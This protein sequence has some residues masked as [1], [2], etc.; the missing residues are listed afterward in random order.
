LSREMRKY[1]YGLNQWPP[2]LTTGVFAVQWLMILVPGIVVMGEVLG[3]A[4]G[5]TAPQRVEFVQ[6]LFLV[7]GATQIAQV[8]WGHRLPGLVGPAGVLMVGV[9]G[10]LSSGLDVVYWS[11]TWAALLVTL[12]G[13]SGQAARLS[14][15]FT[16]PVLAA[17]LLLLAL[18]LVPVA[19]PSVFHAQTSGGPAGSLAFVMVLVLAMYAAERHFKGLFSSAVVL[20]GMVLGSLVFHLTGLGPSQEI[21]AQTGAWFSLPLKSIGP[22]RFDFGVLISFLLCYLAVISNEVAANEAVGRMIGVRGMAKRMNWAVLLMGLGG[23]AGGLLGV[24]GPVTYSAGPAML[25][26]TKSA[27]RFTLLPA[28]FL[29]I[30][31]GLIPGG[32]SLFQ[33]MP[34]PVV[35]GVLLYLLAGSAIAGLELIAGVKGGLDQ[36]GKVVVGFAI[37][38]GT[39]VAFMPPEAVQS[40]PGPLRPVLANGFVM[41]LST[42]FILEHIVLKKRK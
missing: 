5:L 28:G 3:G 36:H 15:L 21:H 42:A 41:G 11:I 10:T 16:P 24:P 18:C 22:P 9:L 13:L 33:L 17:T 31:L 7:C 37:M 32:L 26:S 4:Q 23:V 27:S 2:P 39:A 35:G 14:R 30:L 29:V 19:I 1:I 12:L 34:P 20:M 8:L 6:R 38:T 40:L 25:I